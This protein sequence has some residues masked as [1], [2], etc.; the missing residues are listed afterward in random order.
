M[1]VIGVCVG[2]IGVC[3][4]VIGVCV[5]VIGVCVG[6]IGVCVGVIGVCVGVGEKSNMEAAVHNKERK[7]SVSPL[8][9]CTS[10]IDA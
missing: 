8:L 3:V 2:V 7:S 4:G 1:R 5:G 9:T 10:T 6:V